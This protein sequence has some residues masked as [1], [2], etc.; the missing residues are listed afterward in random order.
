MAVEKTYPD[1]RDV[2]TKLCG[3]FCGE[4]WR[5]LDRN[6]EYPSEFVSAL[7]DAGYLS[8]LIPQEYGGCVSRK[9]ADVVVRINSS[10][11]LAARD[12]EV[13]IHSVVQAFC[14]PKVSSGAQLRWISEAV[15][16]L[17]L[18]RITATPLHFAPPFG[19]GV[20]WACAA[21]FAFTRARLRL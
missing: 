11:R 5:E 7:T 2:V 16:E 20:S 6:R 21:V 15:G 4:Y 17:D 3:R 12:L 9:G 8:V 19:V 13:S 18:L 10:L 1:I 14:V